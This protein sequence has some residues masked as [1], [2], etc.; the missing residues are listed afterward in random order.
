[1]DIDNPYSPPTANIDDK[2]NATRD[3]EQIRQENIRHEVQ[4][5][6]IGSLYGLA[7]ILLGISCIGIFIPLISSDDKFSTGQESPMMFVGI[8]AFYGVLTTIMLA[9]AYGYR[10]L[11]PWV[12][13]P[14][15][16]LSVIGLLGIPVGTLIN[17]YILY[18]IWC[19]HGKTVLAAGYQDIIRAT[20]HVKYKRTLGDKI[21]TGIVFALLVGVAILVFVSINQ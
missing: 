14:G 16:V 1:M 11:S 13:I 17:G 19:K 4:L 3:M 5:K 8:L 7:G 2:A 18:L 15:T 20:P 6:S 21:A 9:M 10:K 12:K